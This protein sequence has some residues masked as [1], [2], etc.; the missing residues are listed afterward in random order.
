M[1]VELEWNGLE[2]SASLSSKFTGER[3]DADSYNVIDFNAGYT[4]DINAGPFKSVDFAFVVNN[5]TS[6]SYLAG[7]TGNGLTCF[8]GAP[9]TAA[10]TFTANF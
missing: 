1:L 2:L 7:G 10:F 5:V 8:I 4:A 9:R 3:G 6:E